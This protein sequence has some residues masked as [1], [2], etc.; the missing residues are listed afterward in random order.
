MVA[1]KTIDYPM[2]IYRDQLWETYKLQ[3]VHKLV[4]T[5]S[6]PSACMTE[7]KCNASLIVAVLGS[8][9]P[10]CIAKLQCCASHYLVSGQILKILTPTSVEARFLV[11]IRSCRY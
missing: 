8:Q 4:A 9:S 10:C 7:F 11:S 1:S 6:G 5:A 2:T 3:D